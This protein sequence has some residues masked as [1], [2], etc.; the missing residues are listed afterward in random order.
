VR[1][2]I[3]A[4]FRKLP[5]LPTNVTA[6][7]DLRRW[8]YPNAGTDVTGAALPADTGPEPRPAVRPVKRTLNATERRILAYCRRAH[9]KGEHISRHLG[10]S[11]EY[12][13]RVLARLMKEGRLRNTDRGYRTV[14]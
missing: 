4:A 11:Y 12:T 10:L 14:A 13:R 1:E 5:R 2:A 8:T 7:C 3:S 9:H 6:A